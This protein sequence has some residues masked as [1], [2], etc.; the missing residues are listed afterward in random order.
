MAT[1]IANF[2]RGVDMVRVV[3][4]PASLKPA[5]VAGR[6]VVVFDVLRATTT[7]TAALAAG[8]AEVRVFEHIEAA[9]DAA[10]QFNAAKVLCGE[11][12]C[13]PPPGFDLGNS[14]RQWAGRLFAGRTA[15]MCTTNGTRAIAAAARLQPAALLVGGLINA[16]SLAAAVSATGNNVTLLCAGTAG[17]IS[18][19]DVL[20][21]GAVIDE[22]GGHPVCEGDAAVMAARLFT[23][24]LGDLPAALRQGAG[25]RNLLNV[26]L[27]AD[28]EF[29]AALN[30]LSDVGIVLSPQHGHAPIGGQAVKLSEQ[31][32]GHGSPHGIGDAGDGIKIVH[33]RQAAGGQ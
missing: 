25:G 16:R 2:A 18:L 21:A 13:L 15:F 4:T 17:E 33:Q 7:I 9:R 3:L 8:V 12:N 5:D 27:E 30:S 19:E 10:A 24:A 11:L 14:P 29:C 6:T 31:A 32:D 26:E 22:L 23:Q 28:I 1:V 20:G